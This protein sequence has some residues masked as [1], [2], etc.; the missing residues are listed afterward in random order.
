MTRK[1]KSRSAKTGSSCTLTNFT[2]FFNSL[3]QQPLIF[4]FFF[5][6]F[7]S[8][9]SF[10]FLLLLGFCLFVC[11]ILLLGNNKVTPQKLKTFQ[12]NT[13]FPPKKSLEGKQKK[14]KTEFCYRHVCLL[15][16]VVW[17][18][19]FNVSKLCVYILLTY[20]IYLVRLTDPP[21]LTLTLNNPYTP[22]PKIVCSYSTLS[23]SDFGRMKRRRTRHWT[24]YQ[25]DE[26]HFV[27]DV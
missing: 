8:F 24:S 10:S 27:I 5:F 2:E 25:P 14:K 6:F 3:S 1:P 18:I 15:S 13:R 16:C 12:H 22:S 17:W 7:F 19:Y 23:I 9:F 21:F 20:D 26:W 4:P 11:L